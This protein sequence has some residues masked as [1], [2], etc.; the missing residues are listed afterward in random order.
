[1][2]NSDSDRTKML[3]KVAESRE[4]W[5]K[6]TCFLIEICMLMFR[7]RW[8]G[9]GVKDGAKKE[10]EPKINNF[11]SATLIL[12]LFYL[13]QDNIGTVPSSYVTRSTVVSLRNRKI[14]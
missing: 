6:N 2:N 14:K 12:F 11:G 5:S 10:P 13:I 1:M 4:H 9:K 7:K 8:K 3:S